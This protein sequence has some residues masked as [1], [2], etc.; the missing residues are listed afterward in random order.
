[1]EPEILSDGSHGIEVCAAVT[2][3]VLAAC[4]KVKGVIVPGARIVFSAS[5][6]EQRGGAFWMRASCALPRS[7]S[8]AT[9]NLFPFFPAM[10]ALN[11]HHALLEGTLLK[12]NMVLAGGWQGKG[13]WHCHGCAPCAMLCHIEACCCGC[14]GALVGTAGN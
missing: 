6:V 14:V 13:G 4:Y 2:E 1:M 7:P 3:R 12:P 11:D 9:H 8:P 10:Q 5:C